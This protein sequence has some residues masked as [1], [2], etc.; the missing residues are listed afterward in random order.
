MSWLG[1]IIIGGLAGWLA[2]MLMEEQRGCLTNIVV[3]IIGGVLGG[4]LFNI[5]GGV[6]ITGFNLWSLVVAVVGAIILLG[7]INL[8]RAKKKD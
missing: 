3:G 4:F 6:G 1:W 2:S 7:I 8:F 5:I